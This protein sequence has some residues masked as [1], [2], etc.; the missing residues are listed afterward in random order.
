MSEFETGKIEALTT[1]LCELERERLMRYA[2]AAANY[3]GETDYDRVKEKLAET[4]Q[5]LAD[6]ESL[7]RRLR[8]DLSRLITRYRHASL[9]DR[10][11][12][13]FTGRLKN[14]QHK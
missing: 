7:N 5:R 8:I 4:E 3:V 14:V 9:L 1:D 2:K 12:Y 10:L 6:T 13:L 11:L